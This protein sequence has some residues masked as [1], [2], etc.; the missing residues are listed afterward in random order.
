MIRSLLVGGL[1]A[2]ALAGGLATSSS[3]ATSPPPGSRQ[4]GRTYCLADHLCT[5]HSDSA[6][7]GYY[8]SYYSCQRVYLSDWV[9]SGEVM[10]NQS[11]GTVTTFY[12]ESGNVISTSKAFQ[13]VDISWDAIWSF[14]VCR[15]DPFSFRSRSSTCHLPDLKADFPFSVTES[16][17][18]WPWW[19]S[20]RCCP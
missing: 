5:F 3:A 4:F 10:N 15:T 7:N 8:N 9:G 20:R 12:G 17:P 2:I 19:A 1:V 16:S 14:Q 6:H 13:D 18:C 11:T